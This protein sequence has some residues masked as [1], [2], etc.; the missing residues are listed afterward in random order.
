MSFFIMPD[1]MPKASDILA[2]HGVNP[3]SIGDAKS[4]APDDQYKAL[5]SFVDL[6]Q[7]EAQIQREF[8]TNSAATAN[9]VQW[10]MF[11]AAN[12]NSARAADL[13]YQRQ[14]EREDLAWQRNVEM[15][16][17]QRQDYLIDRGNAYQTM[18]ADLKKAG[19]NPILA[20]GN[21]APTSYG[22]AHSAQS[23]A[24][25]M[26]STAGVP[27]AHSAKGSKAELSGVASYLST[28]VSSSASAAS[29]VASSAVSGF[30]SDVL[31][32]IVT[33]ATKGKYK[34]FKYR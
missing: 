9:Q 4:N 21:A 27:S 34:G 16:E 31:P 26:A 11:H 5:Q 32:M 10:D 24:V 18:A 3:S 1:N 14:V 23:G 13:A 28:L 17:K 29:N 2:N 8:E 20:L 15:Y 12:E 33:V 22:S 30:I 19:F 25:S 7:N 6:V